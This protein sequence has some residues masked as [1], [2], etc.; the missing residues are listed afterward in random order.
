MNIVKVNCM[1]NVKVHP[2][3]SSNKTLNN[4]SGVLI[5]LFW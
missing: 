1:F 2:E 5:V 3:S 4:S